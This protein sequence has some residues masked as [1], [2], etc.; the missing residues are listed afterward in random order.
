[1]AAH[2]AAPELPEGF[3]YE[4]KGSILC[5]YCCKHIPTGNDAVATHMKGKKHENAKN[6]KLGIKKKIKKKKKKKQNA[7]GAAAAP[8]RL[9]GEDSSDDVVFTDAEKAKGSLDIEFDKNAFVASILAKVGKSD[10][11]SD[12]VLSDDNSSDTAAIAKADDLA[13]RTRKEAFAPLEFRP[14]DGVDNFF[15]SMPSEELRTGRANEFRS[16]FD[17]AERKSA[18]VCEINTE[19]PVSLTLKVHSDTEE[20]GDANKA[21]KKED[22]DESDAENNNESLPPW[23]LGPDTIEAVKYCREPSLALHYDIL[24]FVRFVSPTEAE[25]AN[26]EKIV[27]MVQNIIKTLWP[28]SRLELFGSHATG[29]YL[30]TSDIDMCV[31]G[32]PEEGSE[33]EMEKVAHAVRNV[34]GF[35]RRVK[36]IKARVSLVKLVA[37]EGN[38]QCDISF[39]VTNGPR[40]VPIIRQY[41]ADFPALRPLLLVIKC[42]LQQRTLNEVYSGGL[43]SYGVLLLV[44]SHLQMLRYNYPGMS[45]NLGMALQH[46]FQ[47]YGRF[48]NYCV[49]GIAVKDEG[50][51]YNKV[52]RYDTIPGETLRY[53][54]EDPN[55]ID[56][57]IGPNSFAAARVRKAFG[58]AYTHLSTWRRDDPSRPMSPLATIIV[59]DKALRARRKEVLEDFTNRNVLHLSDFTLASIPSERRAQDTNRT[60]YERKRGD[61]TSSRNYYGRYDDLESG[62][63]DEAKRVPP[64]T[65]NDYSGQNMGA[66]VSAYGQAPYME[67][68]PQNQGYAYDGSGYSYPPPPMY[69]AHNPHTYGEGSVHSRLGYQFEGSQPYRRGR[70]DVPIR[71]GGIRKSRRPARPKNPDGRSR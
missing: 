42:F 58:N 20:D 22:D 64:H 65:A 61:P 6:R 32:T 43:G 36:L 39:G 29:L 62:A 60:G 25:K 7:A 14:A 12:G 5:E 34:E 28:E 4:D 13:A 44:V 26:R 41:L 15:D 70:H 50:C 3:V 1:M 18:Q 67:P 45:A 49:T 51:Y 27:S 30:P 24:E 53:S 71:N 19:T 33:A 23:L 35:A 16:L 59:P 55:D 54:M 38:V 2:F 17:S 46:F 8:I 31:M 40:N 47:L 48:F 56:N 68:P 21:K 37:R 52:Q 63:Y 57:E 10:D 11:S 69:P 9:E 66:H